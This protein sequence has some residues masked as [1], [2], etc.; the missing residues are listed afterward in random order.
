MAGG[1]IIIMGWQ[2]KI[3]SSNVQS[4][5]FIFPNGQIHHDWT[6]RED[7]DH[8]E[9]QMPQIKDPDT[10]AATTSSDAIISNTTTVTGPESEP[11]AGLPDEITT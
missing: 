9:V 2:K 4:L 3:G 1:K 5:N 7:A 8:L 6:W 10:T 11:R